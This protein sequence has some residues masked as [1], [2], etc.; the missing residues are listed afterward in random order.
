MHFRDGGSRGDRFLLRLKL[1]GAVAGMLRRLRDVPLLSLAVAGTEAGTRP[2][3]LE[4]TRFWVAVSVRLDGGL[5][6]M[7]P[8]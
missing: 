7:G 5:S 6:S 2:S 3:P 4:T 8:L 1:Q